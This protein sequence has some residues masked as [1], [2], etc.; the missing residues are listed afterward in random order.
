MLNLVKEFT[1]PPK[2]MNP[3]DEIISFINPLAGARR[4]RARIAVNQL[5]KY[6]AAGHGRRTNGWGVRNSSANIETQLALDKLRARSRDLDRNNPYATRAINRIADNVVGTGIR[7]TIKKGSDKIKEAWKEW[8]KECD[9]DGQITMYGM[10][11]LAIKT[12]AM[13]GEC[14]IRKRRTSNNKKS[15]IPIQLQI[16]EPEIID[17]NRNFR[18]SNEAGNKDGYCIQGV[19][20]NKD[21]KR[22]GYWLFDHYPDEAITIKSITSKMVPVEDILH[23]YSIERPGQVRGVPFGCSTFL[24]LKDF[25]DYE[26]AELM[27]QKIAACFSVFITESLD[28]ASPGTGKK[29][30]LTEKV[31]PGTI[32]RLAPG[33]QVSFSNPPTKEGIDLYSRQIL[34]AVAAGYGVTYEALTG[35]MRNV[36]F[37]SGRMGWIEFQRQIEH[38]QNNVMIPMFCERIFSWFLEG[39]EIGLINKKPVTVDWTPP[40]RAMI[41]PE[42]EVLGINSA[43]RAGLL[44]WG[45]AVTE[46]GYD[47]EEVLNSVEKW[48]KEFDARGIIFDS[49]PRKTDAAGKKTDT[50]AP[51]GQPPSKTGKKSPQVKEKKTQ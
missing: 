33:E 45:E 24:R 26:D 49:D 32:N 25:D 34:Q 39:A 22:I 19:E 10:Q 46:Q 2:T 48:N 4:M 37:S 13:S 21:G 47:P 29:S 38:Y 18:H 5:R 23:L 31:E 43:I 9:F 51:D 50:A 17:S 30:E 36:N 20:F 12:M 44:D 14:V 7:P 6:D 1:Q 8:V 27:R 35:D 41:D 42:K 16:F 15:G 3:V 28:T 11:R 40:R